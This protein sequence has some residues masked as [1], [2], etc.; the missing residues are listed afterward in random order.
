[1]PDAA[2]T[3]TAAA[4][5]RETDPGRFE[6][7]RKLVPHVR[8]LALSTTQASARVGSRQ[9]YPV[10]IDWA[11][12]A[13]R[14][15]C[16]CV[17]FLE[18]WFCKHVVALG[19][20]VITAETAP[21]ATTDPV[22]ALLD[23]LDRDALIALLKELAGRDPAVLDLLRTRAVAAGPTD[24]VDPDDL[25]RLVNEALRSRSFIDYRASFGV[26]R[27]AEAVLDQLEALLDA[28][29]A[30]ATSKALLR[31]TVRLRAITL[32][33]D[34]SGG[35]IGHAAQRAVDLY[36]RA[37]REGH[38]NT[39]S[40]AR[41]L[42]KF[43]RDSPGWPNTSLELFAPA[44]DAKAL[45]AYRRGVDDW[46]AALADQDWSSRFEV[47]QARVELADHD[48]DLDRA[49]DLLSQDHERTAHAEII[50][51]LRAADR[52]P[53]AVQWL[54]RAIRDRGIAKAVSHRANP[55]WV[56]PREASELYQQVG[57]LDDA[58]AVWQQAYVKGP[59]PALWRDLL[60]FAAT[61]GRG[62]EMRAWAITTAAEQATRP[63]G[64]GAALITIYLSEGLLDE[65]WAAAEAYGPGHAW[66]AL[67]GASGPDRAV[68]ATS[69]YRRAVEDGLTR[70][71]PRSYR[72]VAAL[73][74]TMR[75]LPGADRDAFEPYVAEIR[76]RYAHRPTFLKTLG[77]K[78]L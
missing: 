55:F 41:W 63:Y 13:P 19:L 26:A 3:L 58:L 50:R 45:A 29:A 7:G 49:I 2:R 8:E 23:S 59:T 74:V 76:Q 52:T 70:A 14:G 78:G 75:E 53:E 12:P 9:T 1:M 28:G 61:I 27:D 21:E 71:D 31:A 17:D 34:D 77:T 57:R 43:R 51:R 65:A 33:A 24:A 22:S 44:F 62:D 60:D 10:T 66:Q 46:S 5:Q 47:Q 35:V 16:M 6:R 69:L 37:C 15:T 73:L 64:N 25:V 54:D 38:P 32:R 68:E 56:E 36:A 67:A 18:G 20:A 39:S 72:D 48:H 11:R 40:L 4:L 42:L 30:D